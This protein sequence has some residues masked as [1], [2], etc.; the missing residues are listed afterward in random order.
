MGNQ[1]K[2]SYIKFIQEFANARSIAGQ[3]AGYGHCGVPDGEM[4]SSEE[5]T[6]GRKGKELSIKVGRFCVASYCTGEAFGWAKVEP[7]QY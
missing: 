3:V 4:R 6:V 1:H 7:A 5:R 2:K